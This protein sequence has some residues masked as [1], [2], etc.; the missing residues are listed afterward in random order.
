MVFH[1]KIEITI[2]LKK[3][4]GTVVCSMQITNNVDSC[5]LN[6]YVLNSN[7]YNEELREKF[8]N[9]ILNQIYDFYMEKIHSRFNKCSIICVVLKDNKLSVVDGNL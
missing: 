7:Q 1:L 5:L 9:E 4:D 3:I 6:F 2:L 8:E